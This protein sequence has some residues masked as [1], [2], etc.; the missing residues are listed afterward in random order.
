MALVVGVVVYRLDQIEKK[1]LKW[2]APITSE[3]NAEKAA[4]T[5]T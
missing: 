2:T 1:T 3:K 5:Q 4:L